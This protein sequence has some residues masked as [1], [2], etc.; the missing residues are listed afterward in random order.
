[1]K[2]KVKNIVPKKMKKKKKQRD[3]NRAEKTRAIRRTIQMSHYLNDNC[4]E[5]QNK[6]GISSLK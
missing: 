2:D 1:M 4:R 3:K 5:G 6:M